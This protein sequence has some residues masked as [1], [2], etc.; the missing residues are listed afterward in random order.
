MRAR[1]GELALHQLRTAC[2]RD[3]STIQ[4][5]VHGLFAAQCAQLQAYAVFGIG[6]TR[7]RR[8]FVEAIDMQGHAGL[9]TIIATVRRQR[10][11][12]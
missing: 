7:Q 11:K 1:I 12:L 2:L 8:A 5:P 10:G 6:C 9:A 3:P 4:Q